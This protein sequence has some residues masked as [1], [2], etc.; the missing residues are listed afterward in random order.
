MALEHVLV[1]K[2]RYDRLI[3][4]G[5]EDRETDSYG[6]INK[7][8]E[9]DGG[10]QPSSG[11][12]HNEV[13]DR[14]EQPQVALQQDHHSKSQEAVTKSDGANTSTTSRTKQD[15]MP[16][17]GIQLK[18]LKRL[19]DLKSPKRKVSNRAHIDIKKRW[20]KW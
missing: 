10:T 5:R 2:T 11:D 13:P 18:E 19:M 9:Q 20:V 1:P 8:S 17:P 12:G 6:E 7:D 15:I 4:A 3:K 16:P 14:Q